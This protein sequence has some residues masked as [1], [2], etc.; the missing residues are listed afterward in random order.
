[1]RLTS[2]LVVGDEEAFR[3][4]HARYFDRLLRYLFVVTR[5]DEQA[6]R[7]ALQETFT[8]VV[9]HIRRFESEEAL[10]SWLT[11]I[12]RS[13]AIDAGRKR[14][15]YWRMLAHCAF[16][17][18]VADQKSPDIHATVDLDALL[19]VAMQ[20]LEATDRA[21]IEQKYFQSNSVRELAVRF[22]MTEKAVE[23]RLARV[24]RQLREKLSKLLRDEEK[25]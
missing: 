1:M 3:E 12:A 11:I 13:A 5:G 24:R 8:R 2:A 6:A 15:R 20:S 10:W 4:L 19:D 14:A 16:F 23:S 18:R 25:R 22:Q 17:W 9:R 7:D 21:L